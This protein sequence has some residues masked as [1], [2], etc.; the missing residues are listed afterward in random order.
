MEEQGP[1]LPPGTACASPGSVNV[2]DAERSRDFYEEFTPLR[3]YGAWH[4]RMHSSRAW[5]STAR[6]SS[7]TCCATDQ[8]V[9]LLGHA[10]PV[11]RPATGRRDLPSHTNPGYFRICFQTPDGA[12][13][14][15]TAVAAGVQPLSLSGSRSP[16]APRDDRSLRAR[17]GRRG[18]RVPHHAGRTPPLPRELQHCRPR[19]R[20]RVFGHLVGLQCAVRSTTTDLEEHSFGPGGDLHT[21]DARLYMTPMRDGSDPQT[22]LLDVVE[23]TFPPP[24]GQAYSS[25]PTSASRGSRSR[26]TTWRRASHASQCWCRVRRRAARG[27][28]VRRSDREP[29]GPG[30]PQPGRCPCRLGEPRIGVRGGSVG[31]TDTKAVVLRFFDA[32]PPATRRGCGRCSPTMRSG[33]C[34]RRRR[35]VDRPLTGADRV[36]SG[37]RR[38]S[39]VF[40]PG[41]TTWDVEHVTAEDDRV[42]IL[43][44]RRAV[45]ANG[46]PYA[47]QY[48]WLFRF[49]SGR[50]A[51]IWEILDTAL[52][53]SL[54]GLEPPRDPG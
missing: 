52:A 6:R 26:W 9:G 28:G 34:H 8:P 15:D 24:V 5:V 53:I 51:E 29:P 23:S 25:R 50:I 31:A 10:H 19:P 27:V 47:N 11:A 4:R 14:Y 46:R 22:F 42:A 12:A 20:R 35:R 21:Y 33:G 39:S 37:R 17:P 36:A 38:S 49:E 45:G 30:P 48:H 3:S 1:L 7:D 13:L 44:E 40:Q 41:T 32:T 18:A 2:T 43:I 16:A 54:L